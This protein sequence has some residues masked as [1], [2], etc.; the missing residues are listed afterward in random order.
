MRR[1]ICRHP[2]EKMLIDVRPLYFSWLTCS[3]YLRANGVAR[4][5]RYY[6]CRQPPRATALHCTWHCAWDGAMYKGSCSSQHDKPFVIGY[7]MGDVGQTVRW[8]N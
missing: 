1:T 8:P 5:R 6:Q 3:P 4:V 2:V 7:L